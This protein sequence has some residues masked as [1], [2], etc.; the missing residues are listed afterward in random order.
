MSTKNNP[1]RYDCL[2]KLAPDEPYFVL[3]G[4]DAEA[5]DLVELW[6]LRAKTAGCDRDKVNE[7]M[8]VADEMRRWPK[9]KSPD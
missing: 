6:A 1:G 5:A 9:R 3:R 4:Q 8:D 7:A 2:A